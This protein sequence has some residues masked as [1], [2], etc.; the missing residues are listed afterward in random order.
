MPL[1]QK[2]LDDGIQAS[3]RYIQASLLCLEPQSTGMKKCQPVRFIARLR[4]FQELGNPY[5]IAQ[6]GVEGT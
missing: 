6:D 4:K 3:G 2:V 1:S 5:L